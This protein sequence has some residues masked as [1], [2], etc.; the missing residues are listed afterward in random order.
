LLSACS[1][2]PPSEDAAADSARPDAVTS[3]STVPNP[4][5]GS[6]A[7]LP[8][9]TPDSAPDAALAMFGLDTRPMNSSCVAFARPTGTAGVRANR[10]LS[11]QPNFSAV[12][13]V[14]QAPGDNN[15]WYFV[16]K[17][18]RV[19]RVRTTGWAR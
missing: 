9:A 19:R 3:D 10:A 5:S 15:Y 2:P 17:I 13:S 6:D 11:M 18:G 12:T 8:D 1:Q 4:D 14:V 16:E 7:T